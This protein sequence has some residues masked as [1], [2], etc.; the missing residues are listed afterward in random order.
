[1]VIL[2]RE[3]V[4]IAIPFLGFCFYL[5][6]DG[7]EPLLLSAYKELITLDVDD[8]ASCE[9]FCVSELSVQS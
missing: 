6:S 2:R 4:L 1:M 7:R 8:C 5:A 3:S 9:N